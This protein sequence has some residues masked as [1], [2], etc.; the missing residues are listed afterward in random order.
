MN[1]YGCV[2][3]KL[4]I[5]TGG[6]PVNYRFPNLVLESGLRSIHIYSEVL[7]FIAPFQSH[8]SRGTGPSPRVTYAW[9]SLAFP[10]APQ[11][12]G[13]FSHYHL[14]VLLGRAPGTNWDGPKR[15]Q[16]SASPVAKMP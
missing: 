3:I 9:E 7:A 4:F 10:G 12:I 16:C 5:R 1:G 14:S 13:P 6:Q 11:G 8:A 2:T 15:A